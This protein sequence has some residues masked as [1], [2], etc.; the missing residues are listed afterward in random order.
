MR[1]EQRLTKSKDFATVY[2]KGRAFSNK[3]VVLRP[4]ANSLRRNRYGFVVG[5]GVGGAVLRNKVK[6]RLRGAIRSLPLES[7]WDVV[8]I[9][10]RPAAAADYDRLRRSLVGVLRRAGILR[11]SALDKGEKEGQE[12]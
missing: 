11:S 2:G 12:G 4:A 5:R 7:G 8:V 3:L 6:R 1:R 9:A 10:R